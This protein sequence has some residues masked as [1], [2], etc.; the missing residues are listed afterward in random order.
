MTKD[1]DRSNNG[2]KKAFYKNKRIQRLFIAAA[3]IVLAFLIVLNG[4]TPRKY[5]VTLGAISEYDIISPRDIVN[6]VKTEENARKAASQVS[7]VMRDIPNAP[8]EVINLVDKLFFLI[9]DAQNTYKS[10]FLQSP[11]AAA[12]KNLLQMR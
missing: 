6:T 8:I 3:A 9:N 12:M 4:A 10:K 11:A 5:R 2:S 7:P 1:K